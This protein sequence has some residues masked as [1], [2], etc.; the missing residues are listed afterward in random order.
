L[1]ICKYIFTRKMPLHATGYLK[2]CIAMPYTFTTLGIG[3]AAIVQ[4]SRVIM[5]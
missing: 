3:M 5:A 2:Q 4:N 1:G